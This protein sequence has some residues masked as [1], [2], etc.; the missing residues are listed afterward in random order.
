MGPLENVVDISETF[1]AP[2]GEHP[3]AEKPYAE[4]LYVEQPSKEESPADYGRT[5]SDEY[6]HGYTMGVFAGYNDKKNGYG[7]K[8]SYDDDYPFGGEWREYYQRGYAEGYNKGYFQEQTTIVVRE[9][10]NSDYDYSDTYINSSEDESE[11]EYW[12]K[13]DD[14]RITIYAELEGCES[15][16]EAEDYDYY[17]IEEDGRFFVPLTIP[18]GTYKVEV[19]ER[20]N[21]KMWRLDRKNIFIKL[22]NYLSLSRLDEGVLDTY[23]GRGTF[24]KK[25]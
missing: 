23:G 13:W 9:D 11:S 6:R 3:N 1:V 20:V 2:I 14:S 4:E 24:Y 22:N 19:T 8:S 10:Y 17:A 7:Y 5:L 12:K 15:I 16:E 25:P 18:S 21:S